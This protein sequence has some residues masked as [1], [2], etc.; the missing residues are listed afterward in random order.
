M[1]ITPYQNHY[2]ANQVAASHY[3]QIR[4]W[5]ANTFQSIQEILINNDD[6]GKFTLDDLA[7]IGVT[8]KAEYKDW[9][10]K[11]LADGWSE[12]FNRTYKIIQNEIFGI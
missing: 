4:E 10:A 8:P 9:N 1:N 2:I 3:F 7:K 5:N 6:W 11:Q 12:L